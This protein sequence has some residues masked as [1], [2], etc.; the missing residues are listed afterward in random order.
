MQ[1]KTNKPIFVVRS[2]VHKRASS[3]RVWVTIRICFP[4]QSQI[5]WGDFPVNVAIA[6][7]IGAARGDHSILSAMDIWDSELFAAFGQSI[8]DLILVIARI[9]KKSEKP[10]LSS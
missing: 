5:G 3:L 2:R 8:D 6:Y 7:Q 9:W 4:W 1:G 10:G